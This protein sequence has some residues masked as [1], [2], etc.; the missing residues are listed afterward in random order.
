MH[1]SRSFN[2][3]LF[4]AA[5]LGVNFECLAQ[6]NI[7]IRGRILDAKKREPVPFVN[8]YLKKSQRGTSSSETGEFTIHLKTE[9][10]SDTLILSAIGYK[11]NRVPS[12]T[13]AKSE[14]QLIL[15][16]EDLVNLKEVTVTADAAVDIIRKAIENRSETYAISPHRL[17]GVY[18]I[19]DREDGAYTRLIEA[20]V[21][22]Y[23]KDYMNE[24]SRIVDYVAI[25]Q[26]NDY[27]TFRWKMDKLNSRT[28]EE[29]LKPDLIK[30]PT[31]ATHPNGFKKGF[32]YAFER[33]SVLDGKEIMVIS[34]T[35]NP[36]YEW[37]NY[38]AT[39]YVRAEDLAIVRVDRDYSIPRPNWA[40]EYGV[41]TR[42][43]RDQLILQYKDYK[44]KLYL[45]SL[46]WNLSGDVVDEKSGEKVIKFERIEEL[47]IEKVLHEPPGVI[48]SAWDKDIY[49]MHEPYNAAFWESFP[50]ANTQLFTNVTKELDERE[51]LEEQ[52][53]SYKKKDIENNFDLKRQ[54]SA[55]ELNED[56]RVLRLSLEEGHPAIYRYTQREKMDRLFD[57]TNQLLSRPMTE[58]E[59]CRT[60]K[61]VIAAIRCGHTQ[62]RLSRDHY[63]FIEHRDYIFPVRSTLVNDTL[64]AKNSLGDGSI[65]I[66]DMILSIN[67]KSV[68]DILGVFRP[69]IEGDGY[70]KTYADNIAGN[71]FA[72]L[73]YIHF[74]EFDVFDIRTKN[75]KEEIYDHKVPAIS[76]AQL[77]NN[78][79]NDNIS[80]EY[81]EIKPGVGLLKVGSFIDS[82]SFQFKDW[83]KK[84]FEDISRKEVKH[85][86]IDIRDNDGGRDD[87]A[88]YFYSFLSQKPFSYHKSLQ[89][90]T[91]AY[92][93]LMHTNQDASLNSMMQRITTKD[94]SGRFLLNNSHPT[95]GIHAA[96]KPNY[97]GKIY[98]L[99]NGG[100]FSAAADFAAVC[101]QN[102]IGIFVGE[103]T[104]GAAIGNTS[105]G[106]VEVTLPNSKIRI[107][108]PLFMIVNAVDNIAPGRGVLP[109]H[110]IRRG[111]KDIQH[112]FDRSLAFV[113]ELLD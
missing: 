9:D 108:L 93:F 31:R 113:F 76:F 77:N 38:N 103:E 4:C 34:A 111:S 24:D 75:I 32:F 61:P 53:R 47:N 87:Y 55:Q 18:R 79:V 50:I 49:K 14:E 56:F 11:T 45:N 105:N 94:P 5:V 26:S 100:T 48:R 57:S 83:V 6:G 13:L 110:E 16:D 36:A 73:Y 68:S 81:K 25:R 54:F 88:M 7:L 95:L 28:V 112:N 2:L 92:S 41:K 29:L 46:T 64:I 72:E 80:N 106:E 66:G 30:R 35:K 96:E 60:I 27:R 51:N 65:S 101:K 58:S 104:G 70:I 42:I 20:A 8:V 43:T 91:N 21:N 90:S 85:L 12:Q 33:Y 59:F 3:F 71:N 78:G 99:I 82:P 84:S 86:I 74:G 23:D 37:P 69:S 52:F 44:G 109:D 89:A 97:N 22:I 63:K 39:F 40:R 15:L 10:L 62:S 98:I 102:Q 1:L 107:S 17:Q 19:A 67:G